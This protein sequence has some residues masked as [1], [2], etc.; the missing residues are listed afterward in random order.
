MTAPQRDARIADIKRQLADIDAWIE[1]ARSE[2]G[3][4]RC[5]HFYQNVGKASELRKELL[6][7]RDP[8]LYAR[9]YC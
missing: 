3:R 4:E 1:R 6:R 9:L 8:E 7:L 5:P 2:F